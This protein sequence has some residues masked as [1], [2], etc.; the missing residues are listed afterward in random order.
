MNSGRG[1]SVTGLFTVGYLNPESGE[2]G[3]GENRRD[4]LLQSY[5]PVE[6]GEGGRERVCVCVVR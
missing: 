4:I 1:Y 5:T 2:R 3:L 6:V